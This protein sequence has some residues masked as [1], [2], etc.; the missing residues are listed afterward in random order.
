MRQTRGELAGAAR[1]S[2]ARRTCHFH[3]LHVAEGRVDRL[4]HCRTDCFAQKI[5]QAYYRKPLEIARN[6]SQ[7]MIIWSW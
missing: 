2:P 5:L 4:K 3:R 6:K 7:R 1:R